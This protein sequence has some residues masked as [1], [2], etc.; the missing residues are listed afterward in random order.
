MKPL[1][2]HDHSGKGFTMVELLVV[3]VLIGLL[4][5]WAWPGLQSLAIKARRSEG[6]AALVQAM[7]QQERYY[8]AH[9]SYVAFSREEPNGF[10]WY[11]GTAPARS[12]YE[13]Q[14]R[15]C[16]G[17]TLD[18]CVRIEASPGTAAVNSTSA[19]PQCG[20]LFLTSR[21]E[22]GADGDSSQCWR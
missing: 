1:F 11:S 13:L 6:R 22:R 3:L 2:A 16:P 18:S 21:G 15:A 17:G 5:S 8:T 4:A 12:A 19:D 10:L 14:A 20:T 9:N 7:Q